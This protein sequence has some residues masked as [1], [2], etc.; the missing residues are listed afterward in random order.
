MMSLDTVKFFAQI[1]GNKLK[2]KKIANIAKFHK[3]F[4]HLGLPDM[5]QILEVV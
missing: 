1:C 2:D 5:S 3:T 4:P